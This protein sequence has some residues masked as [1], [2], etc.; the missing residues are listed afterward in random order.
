MG[1]VIFKHR[2]ETEANRRLADPIV[3][4][5]VESKLSRLSLPAELDGLAMPR[6]EM[7]QVLEELAMHEAAVPWVLWNVSF[8]QLL[9]RFLDP[10]VR[11]EVFADPSWMIAQS[12]RFKGTAE[13]DGDGYRVN[14]QWDLVS[15]CEL[16]EWLLLFCLVTKGGEVQTNDH[17]PVMRIVIVRK[18]QYEILDTWHSGGLRGSG[19]HDVVVKDVLVPADHTLWISEPSTIDEPIGRVAISPPDIGG[20]AAMMIGLAQKSIDTVVEMARTNI[21]P[22]PIPDLRDRPAAQEAVARRRAG[23]AGARSHLH[24]CVDAIWQRA[25]DGSACTNE[26]RSATFGAIHHANLWARDTVIEM[27]GLGGTRALYTS[28]PLERIHRDQHTMMRHIAAMPI[29]AEN[30]GRVMFGMDPEFPLF[31][32]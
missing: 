23:L 16:A 30:S 6:T 13:P 31:S 17:G 1:D 29:W 12:T 28:S 10:A 14:G 21:T 7:L 19:S 11:R 22:G 8:F 18:G 32:V 5:L 27:S 25:V 9:S 26:E 3:A 20:F 2:D 15:G 4:A 24:E